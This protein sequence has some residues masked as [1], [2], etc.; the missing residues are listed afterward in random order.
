M[1]IRLLASFSDDELG[2]STIRSCLVMF[3]F[4]L[5]TTFTGSGWPGAPRFTAACRVCG[6]AMST[7]RAGTNGSLTPPKHPVSSPL[8]APRRIQAKRNMATS[9]LERRRLIAVSSAGLK[10]LLLYLVRLVALLAW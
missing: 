6:G 4:G 5:R 10:L 3:G 1:G 8:A 9:M 7:S 2:F